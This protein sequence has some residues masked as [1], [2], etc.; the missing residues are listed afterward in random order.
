MNGERLLTA[1]RRVLRRVLG[2]ARL[3]RRVVQRRRMEKG[4]CKSAFRMFSEIRQYQRYWRDGSAADAYFEFEL[5]RRETTRDEMFAYI[6]HGANQ[7]MQ[8]LANYREYDCTA[9]DKRFEYLLFRA[10]GLPHPEVA[11]FTFDG[12]ITDGCFRRLD[13]QAATDIILNSPVKRYFLK[14][15][16][17]G[18]A[19]GTDVISVSGGRLYRMN[20]AIADLAGIVKEAAALPAGYVLQCEMRNQHAEMSD[21]NPDTVNTLRI[22]THRSGGTSRIV[23]IELRVGRKG[24]CFDNAVA[25]GVFIRVDPLS[26]E[27]AGDCYVKKP[28][29][30]CLGQFHPDTNVKLSGVSIPFSREIRELVLERA[31]VAFHEHPYLGWD[32]AVSDSGPCLIEVNLGFEIGALQIAAGRGLRDDFRYDPRRTPRQNSKWTEVEQYWKRL[33]KRAARA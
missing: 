18:G 19:R 8:R 14:P 4:A 11:L 2:P 27:T 24:G 10:M 32:V 31:A 22:A 12:E 21:L 9:Y 13:P 20:G 26:F 23:G 1:G 30:A 16:F 15:A 33:E 29:T 3:A 7:R 25:G 5:H 28:L 17:S 6:P